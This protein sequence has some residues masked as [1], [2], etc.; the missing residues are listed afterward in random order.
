[1]NDILC[2]VAL[3]IRGGLTNQH[4]QVDLYKNIW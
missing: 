1:M 2:I 3:V 4:A